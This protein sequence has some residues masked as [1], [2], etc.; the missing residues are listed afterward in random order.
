MKPYTIIVQADHATIKVFLNEF[1]TLNK[2]RMI[3]HENEV[4]MSMTDI[5]NMLAL[6]GDIDSL[7]NVY[8]FRKV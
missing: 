2:V 3:S 5:A 8:T 1:E 6:K 7:M 4:Y